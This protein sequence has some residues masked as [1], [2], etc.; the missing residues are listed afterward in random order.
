MTFALSGCPKKLYPVS[1]TPSF[2]NI[3]FTNPSVANNERKITADATKETAAG[4][5]MQVR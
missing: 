5:K 4:R 2:T 1:N 3:T